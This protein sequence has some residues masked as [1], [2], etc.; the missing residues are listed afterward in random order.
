M[1]RYIYHSNSSLDTESFGE[2]LSKNFKGGEVILLEGELGAGKTVLVKGIA[3]G[4]G[5]RGDINSPT[6]VIIKSYDM[7]RLRFNHIDLYRITNLEGIG[8]EEYLD[9]YEAITVV[10]W[11]EKIKDSIEEYLFIKFEILDDN[12]RKII[13]TPM[14]DRYK[15]L[16]GGIRN[17]YTSD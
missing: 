11:G 5:I 10:E 4:L 12:S 1:D 16:V 2:S 8:I 7:G 9:D 15:K 14:G 3:K 17:V 13:F 6:F